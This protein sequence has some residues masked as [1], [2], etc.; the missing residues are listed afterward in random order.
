MICLYLIQIVNRTKCFLSSNF[1]MKDLG[2]TKII[3]VVK[4]IRRNDGIMLSQEHYT[5]RLLRKFETF[6]VTLTPMSTPYDTNT[7]LKKNNGDTVV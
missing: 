3:L 4:I 5:E 6:N 7:Q 2:E 1:D